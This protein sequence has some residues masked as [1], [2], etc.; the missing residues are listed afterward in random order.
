[1][2][3]HTRANERQGVVF[4]ILA[5]ILWG[6]F[7]IFTKIGL[8]ALSP[9]VLGPATAMTASLPLLAITLLGKQIPPWH[10]PLWKDL[11]YISIMGTTLPFLLFFAGTSLTSG[12]NAGLLQQTEPVYSLVIS[13]LLLREHIPVKQVVGSLM[14]LLGAIVVM[15]YAFG[16]LPAEEWGGLG[17]LLVVLTPLGYQ[18]A[19]ARTKRLLAAGISSFAIAGFRL[20][21]GGSLLLVIAV[22]LAK[23]GFF[24]WTFPLMAPSVWLGFFGYSIFIVAAEKVLWLEAI[25]RINLSKASGF[26][27]VS[28]LVSALGAVTVLGESLS[29][30]H[31][32]GGALIFVGSFFLFTIPSRQR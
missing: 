24:E 23:Y 17:E 12:I 25:R 19:H 3:D 27:P 28:V 9:F 8:S 14:V 7:P 29:A 22:I 15:G 30:R 32:I 20:M 4:V 21:L 26:L 6:L 2:P 1:M 13:Y 5:V 31:L 10:S 18:L 11:L 16:R